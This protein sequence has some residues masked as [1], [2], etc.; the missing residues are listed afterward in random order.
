M[1]V[2]LHSDDIT[3]L[4]HW[5]DSL[6]GKC[7]MV[8][9]FETLFTCQNAI[10]IINFTAC[11]GECERLFQHAK[12]NE[13]RV[14]VLHRMPSFEIAKE[15]LSHGAFGYGNAFMRSHFIV[16]AVESIQ[17]GMVWLYPEYTMQLITAMAHSEEKTDKLQELSEREKEVALLLKDGVSY[18]DI[19]RELEITPRTVKAHAKNTYTKLGV[20][21]RIGLALYLR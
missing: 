6:E 10:V 17:D 1:K 16:A 7:E 21:D 19:A 5:Q 3:L 15:L 2:I 11:N 12:T 18:K 20:K 8:E 9:E 4:Q 13:L 14:L